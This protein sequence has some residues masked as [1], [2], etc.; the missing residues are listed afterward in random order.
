MAGWLCRAGYVVEA[1]QGH[2]QEQDDAASVLGGVRVVLGQEGDI[3]EQS[4]PWIAVSEFNA[5]FLSYAV[6]SLE[7][8]SEEAGH[9]ESG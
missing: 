7:S 8:S 5:T 6:V 1:V 3:R 4:T 2:S 9:I